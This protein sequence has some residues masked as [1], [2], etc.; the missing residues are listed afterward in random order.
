MHFYEEIS[1]DSW[2]QVKLKFGKKKV[3]VE[4]DEDAEDKD[5]SEDSQKVGIPL[6]D[7]LID[8][9]VHDILVQIKAIEYKRHCVLA[10]FTDVDSMMKHWLWIPIAALKKPQY[11]IEPAAVS[12]LPS[13]LSM[14]FKETLQN[15]SI[16]YAR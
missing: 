6:L 15:T 10:E 13:T 7:K 4:E 8:S 14:R 12:F 9:G 16:A 1:V 3:S 5:V 11:Q 2:V